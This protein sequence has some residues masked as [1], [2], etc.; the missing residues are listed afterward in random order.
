MW[1]VVCMLLV[2]FVIGVI[3]KTVYIIKI[4]KNTLYFWFD[5][6]SL[7]AV[8]CL[9]SINMEFKVMFFIRT[10]IGLLWKSTRLLWSLRWEV[11][12][13]SN[14]D[15]SRELINPSHWIINWIKMNG[16]W[17]V[18]ASHVWNQ[19][20]TRWG[21]NLSHSSFSSYKIQTG[22]KNKN[23]DPCTNRLIDLYYVFSWCATYCLWVMLYRTY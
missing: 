13:F 20:W 1:S 16:E 9:T 14:D 15:E 23:C 12:L 4:K 19:S 11:Y 8:I 5:N 18:L 7:H 21:G 2:Q 22:S 3:S 17:T 10:V 6:K